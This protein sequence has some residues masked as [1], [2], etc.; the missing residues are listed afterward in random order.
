MIFLVQNGPKAFQSDF[1]LAL[2]YGHLLSP[3]EA[4]ILRGG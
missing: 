1:S 3:Q 2:V 4:I